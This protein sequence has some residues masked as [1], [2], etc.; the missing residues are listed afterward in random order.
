MPTAQQLSNQVEWLTR[1]PSTECYSN[2]SPQNHVVY[3]I[4]PAHW[5]ESTR[6]WLTCFTWQDANSVVLS[7]LLYGGA[8]CVKCFQSPV[9]VAHTQLETLLTPLDNLTLSAPIPI[10]LYTLP[11]WSNPQFLIFDIWVLWRSGLSARAHECQKLKIV[12]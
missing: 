9:G 8:H 1:A 7:T 2:Q 6:T 3:R 5:T 10:T 4:H 11:Y 12:G